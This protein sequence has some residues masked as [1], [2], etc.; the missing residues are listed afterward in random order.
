MCIRDRIENADGTWVIVGDSVAGYR[1]FKEFVGLSDFEAVGRTSS[2]TGELVIDGDTVTD[3]EFSVNLTTVTSD[4]PRRDAQ[5]R[6][7][8]LNTDIF[9][10]GTFSLTSPIE[11]TEAALNGEAVTFAATGELTLKGVTNEVDVPLTARLVG[12]EVQVAGS[13]DVVFEDFGIEPPFTPSIVVAD[14]GVVEFSL[15]FEQQAL[16]AS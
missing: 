10:F 2:V 9:R 5:F 15:F 14:E 11:L 12:D 13:I 6:G 16:S 1:V 8:I 7:P 3:A 4:D